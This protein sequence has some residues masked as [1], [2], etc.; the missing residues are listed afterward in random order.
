MHMAFILFM[1]YYMINLF[2]DMLN[3]LYTLI[4]FSK[5]IIYFIF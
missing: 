2:P 1:V 3:N 4:H 5:A